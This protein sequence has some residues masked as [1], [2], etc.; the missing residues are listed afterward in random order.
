MST[1]SGAENDQPRR[2]PGSRTF[3]WLAVVFGV[4]LVVALGSVAITKRTRMYKTIHRPLSAAVAAMKREGL[5]TGEPVL[6]P[7][8]PRVAQAI[9]VTV[10]GRDIHLLEFDLIDPEHWTTLAGIQNAQAT[11]LLG[12]SQ[13]AVVNRPVVMVGHE[14]HPHQDRLLKAFQS[15]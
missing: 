5:N 9:R 14:E 4:F 11:S 6:L 1:L 13:A 7:G 10:E 15:F 12:A 2:P 3:R 8:I